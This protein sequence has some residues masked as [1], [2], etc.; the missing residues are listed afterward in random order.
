MFGSAQRKDSDVG[1]S[2]SSR[3]TPGFAEMMQAMPIAAMTCDINNDFK[4]NFANKATIDALAQIEH[5]LPCRA[6]QI[7]G[8]SIDIFHKNPDMQRRLLSD[9][10]NLPHIAV[11]Q[12]G[13]E[14]LELKVDAMYGKN[15]DY[16]GPILVWSIVTDR[17]KQEENN[18]MLR[19]MMDEMPVNVMMADKDSLEVTYANQTS[20]NTLRAIEH[21]I[22]IKPDDLVGTNIDVFHKNPSFQRQMLADSSSLPHS[23]RIKLGDE[24]LSLRVTAVNGPNGNYV[25]PM[26]VW[27][28]ISDQV[29]LADN[30][31]ESV[32]NVV[33]TVTSAVTELEASAGSMTQT[34]EQTQEGAST[35]SAAVEE[36]AASSS[37]ISQQ[38]V[39]AS[40]ISHKAVE[41]SGKATQ[42]INSLTESATKIGDVIGLIQDI[43]SQTNLLALNATIEAARAG[44]AGKGFAVVAAEVKALASQTAKATE[45]ISSQVSGIQGSVTES[46]TAIQEITSIIEEISSIS[47]SI[48]S[49]VEEQTAATSEVSS[50]VS[51]VA[52]AADETG[53][54]SANVQTAAGELGQQSTEL[55]TRVESFLQEIR[56][57]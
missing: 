24:T 12:L 25:G 13:D 10:R 51:Q 37:E 38:V 36:L 6:D 50:N 52:T 11:I 14:Y 31:E 55:Q 21:L 48:S 19:Q 8:Q 34:A 41:M 2:T 23:A 16:L 54:V 20:V 9:P 18:E 40:T 26:V 15:R 30:F 57:L 22:P 35:V 39:Q 53:N 4:I 49:A 17:V 42:N 56:A 46:A 32:G 44:D 3:G 43:A 28:V 33:T 1:A 45:D 47:M 7:V 27:S 29:R 5:L